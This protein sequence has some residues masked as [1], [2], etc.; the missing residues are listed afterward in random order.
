MESNLSLIERTIFLMELDYFQNVSSD[1]VAQIATDA[2][3]DH[4]E[5]GTVVYGAD[6]PARRLYV[7]IEGSVQLVAEGRVVRTIG[8]GEGFGLLAALQPES[9][10]DME[11]RATQHTHVL[12]FSRDDFLDAIHE[13]PDLPIG[14]LRAIVRQM[15]EF[16]SENAKLRARLA[17]LAGPAEETR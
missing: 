16:A 1:I 10:A 8:R 17:A 11:A 5:P 14:L 6:S 15:T 2:R 13:H 9:A 7:I 3:E 4:F 12:S